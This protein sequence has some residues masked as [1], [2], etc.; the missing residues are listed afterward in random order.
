MSAELLLRLLEYFAGIIIVL[1]L[2]F[3]LMEASRK[4]DRLRQRPYLIVAFGAFLLIIGALM[5]ALGLNAGTL[6]LPFSIIQVAGFF[7]L[8]IG[9]LSLH[10]DRSEEEDVP[11]IPEVTEANNTEDTADKKIE[12]DWVALLTASEKQPTEKASKA[13]PIDKGSVKSVDG[14]SKPEAKVAVEPKQKEKEAASAKLEAS[15]SSGEK[16]SSSADTTPSTP[17]SSTKPEPSPE[18]SAIDLSYLATRKNKIKSTKTA[19]SQKEK[20]VSLEA[21]PQPTGTKVDAPSPE[22]KTKQ[23]ESK[24]TREEILDDLFPIE[25]KSNSKASEDESSLLPGEIREKPTKKAKTAMNPAIALT[26]LLGNKELLALW[27]QA[28]VVLIIFFIIIELLPYRKIRGNGVLLIGFTVLFA[29]FIFQAYTSQAP[30][31]LS[32]VGGLVAEVIGFACLG[33]S[34]WLKIKGKITHHF[35]AIV[36]VFFIILLTVAMGVATVFGSDTTN[37]SLVLN[38]TTGLLIVALPI[39]HAIAYSHQTAIATKEPND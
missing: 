6:Q 39:L 8:G 15:S 20:S 7:L 27:P 33:A 30:T 24:Q 5:R 32:T 37:L 3:V 11:A 31:P 1:A 34:S 26:G 36:S 25:A 23:P 22:A 16:T 9:Y 2:L 13:K 17:L 29:S 35:L 19:A 38:A 28:T 21:K 18:S 10:H 14:P 4:F 12:Q